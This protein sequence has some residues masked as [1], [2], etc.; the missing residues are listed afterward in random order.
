MAR[1]ARAHIDLQALRDNYHWTRQL[2]PGCKALAVVKADAY[3]HGAVKAAHALAAQA[4]GFGVACLEEALEL[5]HDILVM[6]DGEV[7]ARFDL[8]YDTP[9]TRDLLEKMV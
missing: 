4:D 5:G 9:T 1:P 8:S 2:T 3:G 7:S 6:R